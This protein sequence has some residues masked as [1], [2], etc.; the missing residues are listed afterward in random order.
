LD[1]RDPAFRCGF[2]GILQNYL[3]MLRQK[4]GPMLAGAPVLILE[5]EPI[6]AL[7]LAAI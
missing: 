2:N 6:I 1:E 7:D 4:R 3:K 5:D